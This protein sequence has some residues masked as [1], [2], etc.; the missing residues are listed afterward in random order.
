MNLGIGLDLTSARPQAAGLLCPP[1]TLQA[2][3]EA[4]LGTLDAGDAAAD[5]FEKI[6]TWSDLAGGAGAHPLVQATSGN[7]PRARK[8]T[9]IPLIYTNFKEEVATIALNNTT[10]PVNRRAASFFALVELDI[11]VVVSVATE[12]I[13]MSLPGGVGDLISY[14]S[15]TN[16]AVLRWR[17]ASGTTTTTIEL[18]SG[19]ALVGVAFDAGEIRLFY[20]DQSHT[21]ATPLTAGTTTGFS[22]FD[23][24][25]GT[26]AVGGF[27]CAGWYDHAIDSTEL[28]DL[29]AWAVER[30][31][32]STSSLDVIVAGASL[33]IGCFT[34]SASADDGGGNLNAL[35]KY[36]IQRADCSYRNI[37]FAG[38]TTAQQKNNIGLHLTGNLAAANA[39][40][41]FHNT[42]N[43]QLLVYFCPTNDVQAGTAEATII[44]NLTDARVQAR[45]Y[46]YQVIMLG[47]TPWASWDAAKLTKMNNVNAAMAALDSRQYGTFIPRPALL[48]DPTNLT[49]Y[50]ADGVHLKNAG[51]D[52]LY[53][54]IK[55]VADSLLAVSP[56][57]LQTYISMNGDLL[58]SSPYQRDWE[59]VGSPTYVSG[60]W[61]RPALRCSSSGY[62]RGK[63]SWGETSAI[64][65][66]CMFWMRTSAAGTIPVF[67]KYWTA[68]APWYFQRHSGGSLRLTT[69]GLSTAISSSTYFADGNWHCVAASVDSDGLRLYSSADEYP[70]N[71]VLQATSL[72]TPAIPVTT[73]PF[74]VASDGGTGVSIDF[75][76]VHWWF[77]SKTL[78]EFQAI[79]LA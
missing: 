53:D 54:V 40:G 17:D 14:T 8:S 26:I 41:S 23:G 19:L 35:R 20:N 27:N 70:A 69:P 28:A 7:Q 6:K 68:T 72:G 37:S 62:A 52:V 25:V 63:T 58:D 33:G 1:G 3:Y 65:W 75:Q 43:M 55:P 4:S 73:S 10:L 2:Y 77:G 51:F 24:S 46:G 50:D 71:L 18:K 56:S 74:R 34:Q 48:D 13:I 32:L 66:S 76:D 31:A 45:A 57:L 42:S 59:E 79:S 30:K 21:I 36:I 78:A 44:T 67:S 61:G 9:T 5:N 38:T 60:N 16:N 22:L 11:L 64:L 47:M 15:T 12:R 49:Y 39:S 29:R